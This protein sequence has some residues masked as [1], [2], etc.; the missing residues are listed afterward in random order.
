MRTEDLRAELAAAAAAR[1]DGQRSVASAVQRRWRAARR[2][3][4]AVALVAVAAVGVGV[5]AGPEMAPGPQ[6]ARTSAPAAPSGGVSGRL[7]MPGVSAPIAVVGS[8]VLAVHDPETGDRVVTP[9]MRLN[10]ATTAA[11][12]VALGPWVVVATGDGPGSPA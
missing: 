6:A 11:T 7:V 2:A 12:A 8:G 1:P 10:G 4:I 5:V 9:V 3:R